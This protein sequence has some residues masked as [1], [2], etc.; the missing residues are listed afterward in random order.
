MKLVGT[1]ALFVL[2]AVVTAALGKIGEHVGDS[3]GVKLGQKIDP[4]HGKAP[5]AEGAAA[6][7]VPVWL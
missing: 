7:E 1:V 4:N 5:P 6:Q 3:I 2:T